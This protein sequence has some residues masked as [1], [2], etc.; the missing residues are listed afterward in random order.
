MLISIASAKGSPGA[1]TSAHVLAAVWPRPV[2]L[3]E[4]DP[5]G[6]DLVYRT[7]SREGAPLDS[8]RGVVSLAAAIRRDPATPLRD[9]LTVIEGDLPV[10]VGLSRPDQATAIEAGWAGL[11]TSLHQHGDVIA[12]VGRLSPG[13]PSLGAALASDITL[14]VVRPGVENYGHL[15]ERLS[16]I[17]AE[18]SRRSEQARLGI[19][20]I[21]PWKVRHE[22]EDLTRLLRGSNLEVPVVGVLALDPGAADSLAGRQA[23]PLGRTLLVRSARTVATALAG[24]VANGGAR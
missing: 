5:V 4:L 21:A 7:R 12:D 17:I 18:T 16:W 22:A 3:A 13:A 2:V 20:L 6:S 10:L 15:R 14:F 1:S 9:H 19:L 24:V 8:D 11:T 23:R